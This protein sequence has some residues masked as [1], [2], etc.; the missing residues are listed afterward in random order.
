[1]TYVLDTHTLVW[2]LEGGRK[3]GG[4]A[5]AVLNDESVRLLIPSIVLAELRYLG[6]RGRLSLDYKEVLETISEDPR[7]EIVALEVDIVGRMPLSLE[8]HDAII[9]APA[10]LF[11][12]RWAR[13]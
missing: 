11:A 7:M 13:M 4:R 5:L 6:F 8:I 9:C 2:Y 12:A 3:L 1:V 10:M